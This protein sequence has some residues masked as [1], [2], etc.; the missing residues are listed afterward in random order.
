MKPVVAR[1]CCCSFSKNVNVANDANFFVFHV[2]VSLIHLLSLLPSSS[3]SIFSNINC[4]LKKRT[5]TQMKFY[6]D[7]MNRTLADA[8]HYVCCGLIL[9]S[10]ELYQQ[11]RLQNRTLWFENPYNCSNFFRD[12]IA[13]S[14][15]TLFSRFLN[16][17]SSSQF[18]EC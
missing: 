10:L 3:L 1:S 4:L 18:F 15:Q 12:R 17:F 5:Q 8:A 11:S 7:H 13:F 14:E 2:L 16:T 9:H 6:I